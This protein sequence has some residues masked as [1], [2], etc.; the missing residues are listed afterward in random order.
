MRG[1]VVAALRHA[2]AGS[3]AAFGGCGQ[4]RGYRRPGGATMYEAYAVRVN[5]RRAVS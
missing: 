2:G 3:D 1:S 4:W 5:T